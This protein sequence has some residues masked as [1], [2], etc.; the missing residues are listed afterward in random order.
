[1]VMTNR[2]A[3]RP[4]PRSDGHVMVSFIGRSRTCSTPATSA[5]PMRLEVAGRCSVSTTWRACG[6]SL[7][8]GGKFRRMVEHLLS[9]CVGQEVS[10]I[11]RLALCAEAVDAVRS[12]PQYPDRLGP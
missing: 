12:N 2:S 8:T 4:D 3:D 11:A 1:M 9:G 5:P 10:S 6:I 7:H